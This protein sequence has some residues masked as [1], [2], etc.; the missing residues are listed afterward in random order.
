VSALFGAYSPHGL[1]LPSELGGA[2]A[3]A[4]PRPSDVE[5]SVGEG[6][7]LL[8]ARARWLTEHD[9]GQAPTWRDPRT[10]VRVVFDGRLDHHARL[11]ADLGVSERSSDLVLTAC[12]YLRWGEAFVARLRGDF[13]L[14]LWDP[15]RQELWL[16]RDRFG[17]RPLYWAQLR[18][19]TLLFASRTSALFAHPALPETLDRL[20]IAQYLTSSFVDTE[21]TFFAEV[22]RLAPGHTLTLGPGMRAPCIRRYHAFDAA[23]RAPARSNAEHAEAFRALFCEAVRVRVRGRGPWGCLL[24]GGLDSSGLLGAL[25]GL[26]EGR[27]VACFSARFVDFPEIDEGDWLA[28]FD[29]HG[30]RRVELRADRIGPLDRI[31]ALHAALDEPFHAP[32]L[33]VYEGLARLA[34]DHGTRVLL[35]GLDGDTVVDHGYFGLRE[36]LFHGTPRRFV[37]ALRALGRRMGFSHR[38]MLR[39]FVLEPEFRRA[40]RRLAHHGLLRT[41][42]L[43]PEFAE[44]SGFRAALAERFQGW[45]GDTRL[46]VL[47]H[48]SVTSPMLPFYLEVYDKLAAVLGVEH[49]HPYFDSELIAF[50]LA[51]PPEQRLSEGWDRVVQRRAFTGLVPE[52][53]R[54]R[55][56][57]SVW[58][59]N[60]ERQ[61]FGRHRERIHGV[62]EGAS[63]PL[64][65]Y[66]D[67]ARLRRDLPALAAGRAPER[68]MDFWCAVSLGLWLEHRARGARARAVSGASATHG[69]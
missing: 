4:L 21:R 24:S 28:L 3:R 41:G 67:V 53:I 47:H 22:K 58:S 8:G 25:R 55:Q 26:S 69:A 14:G 52:P 17:V 42:Y 38:E 43:L 45:L 40:Q 59:R 51:L 61:L 39:H 54:A 50:C 15:G 35:D 34:H 49:R 13:A 44:R 46:H 36:L 10:G 2:M 65:D 37:R 62:L 64:A 18:D 68:L 60:F 48:Q 57:K 11:A 7:V 12:A 63:T 5:G 6:S 9:V 1:P 56:S 23:R 27:E 32:N 20:R 16:A 19:G 66:C 30:L 33:F 31:D 29:A